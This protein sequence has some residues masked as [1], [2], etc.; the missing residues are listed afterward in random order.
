MAAALDPARGALGVLVIL[1]LISSPFS[2]GVLSRSDDET[3]EKFY[4]NLV[5]RDSPNNTSG[6][7]SI[8]DMFDRVLEKEFSDNDAPEGRDPNSFNNSVADHQAVLETV[9]IISHDKSKKNDSHEAKIKLR[10]M[11]FVLGHCSIKLT[12]GST[13]RAAG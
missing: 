7:G 3:R 5:K 1:A 9:A 6:E 10:Y 2:I 12:L 8:A 4:G 13:N 11:K